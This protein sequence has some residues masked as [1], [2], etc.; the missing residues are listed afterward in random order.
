MTIK[1]FSD[2]YQIPYNIAFKASYVVKPA[3]TF[4]CDREYDEKELYDETLRYAKGRL[5]TLKRQH[6]AYATAIRNLMIRL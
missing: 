2:K 3:A 4:R 6:D 5:K 1:E